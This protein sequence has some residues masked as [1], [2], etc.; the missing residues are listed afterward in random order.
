MRTLLTAA[1]LLCA[2]NAGV[3]CLLCE[4][5]F[6]V[7]TTTCSGIYRLCPADVTHCVQGLENSTIMSKNALTSF[8]DC[9][10]PS[11]R[12]TCDKIL[13][14]RTQMSLVRISR[15]CCDS[16][17]CNGGDIQAL[18]VDESLNGYKCGECIHDRSPDA[19]T[20]KK[21]VLCSGQEKTCL[22]LSGTMILPGEDAVAYSEFGCITNN[23]CRKGGFQLQ[24]LQLQNSDLKCAPAIKV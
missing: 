15:T 11:S 21:E 9:G 19:C 17:Y 5:C 6:S 1:V 23:F 7:G 13:S 18:V 8:K 3:N 22:F 2:L 16:D 12:T 10:T 14:Y 20:T 24:G 4:K